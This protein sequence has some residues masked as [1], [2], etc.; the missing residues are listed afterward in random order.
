LVS[1]LVAIGVVALSAAP[2]AAQGTEVA[3]GFALVNWNG[4]CAYGFGANVAQP[5]HSTSTMTTAIVG[6]FS[7][8]R[9]ADEESDTIFGAGVQFKFMTDQKASPF[10]HATF[11]VVHWSEDAFGP[12]PADSGNDFIA[13]GGGGVVI[14]VTDT[15]GIK[16]QVDVWGANN[17][18]GVITR[19]L[20]AAVVKIGG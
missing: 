17:G 8:T 2:A 19:F 7:W 5:V 14:M 6:D 12:F 3:G 13:G 18:D 1:L 11:G 16:P 10:V 20:I 15:F 9:F 4:C